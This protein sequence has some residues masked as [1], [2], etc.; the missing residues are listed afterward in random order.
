MAGNNLL[1]LFLTVG[2]TSLCNSVTN[3]RIGG[4]HNVDNNLILI[5]SIQ[6]SYYTPRAVLVVA[7]IPGASLIFV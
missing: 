5:L 2:G 6:V 7:L 3:T 1:Y 4:V